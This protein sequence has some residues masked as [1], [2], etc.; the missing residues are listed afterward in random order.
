MSEVLEAG[1]YR[2]LRFNPCVVINELRTRMRGWRPFIVLLAYAAI[3]STAALIALL[4]LV[5]EQQYLGR[6]AV[7]FGRTTF[8]ALAHTQLTL[9]LLIVPAYAAGAI[10]MEREKR[11]LEMLRTSLVSASDVVTGKLLVILAFGLILLLTSLPVASWSILL[12]GVAPEEVLYIYSYLFLVAFFAAALG[13]LYSVRTKR[14]MAAVVATYGTLISTGVLALV[15]PLMVAEIV[16][17]G[18]SSNPAIGREAAFY[19]VLT[20]SAISGWVVFFVVRAAAGRLLGRPRR[21][22]AIGLGLLLALALIALAVPPNGPLVRAVAQV[23]VTA[24]VMLNPYASLSALMDGEVTQLIVFGPSGH[25]RG[26]AGFGLQLWTIICGFFL[27]FAVALWTAAISSFAR[28]T[29]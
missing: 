22:L 3:A 23:S 1:L 20:L 2:A 7:E 28:R 6:S 19:V 24:F 16:L 17:G 27:L 26:V 13:M 8:A 5:L 25:G 14:S 21:R 18:A 11:T 4:P 10:T 15:V 9:I 29:E 12:G